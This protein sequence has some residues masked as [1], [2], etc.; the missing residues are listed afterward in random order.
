MDLVTPLPAQAPTPTSADPYDRTTTSSTISAFPGSETY[1]VFPN[2]A[3]V[4]KFYLVSS[5]YSGLTDLDHHLWNVCYLPGR[6]YEVDKSFDI[7]KRRASPTDS[8]APRPTYLIDRPPCLRQAAIN[9]NCHFKN[10]NGT[11]SGLEVYKNDFD[12]QQQCYCEKYPF[13]DSVLGCMKCFETH[14]GVEGYHWFPKSYVEAA[15]KAYCGQV[16]AQVEFYEFMNQWSKTDPAATVSS[17]TASTILGTQ[18]DASL[19]YTYAAAS[20]NSPSSAVLGKPLGI[21]KMLLA[22]LAVGVAFYR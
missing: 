20:T 12:I 4:S 3:W 11:F 22:A 14:G 1:P 19:Y 6:P 9:A 17:T 10:T 16:P 13:F 5:Q 2:G 15:S 18:T 8:N 7:D 21:R